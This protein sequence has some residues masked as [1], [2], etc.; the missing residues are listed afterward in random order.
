MQVD[1][2][3]RIFKVGLDGNDGCFDGKHL[4]VFISNLSE[5]VGNLPFIGSD[6]QDDSRIAFGKNVILVLVAFSF[7]DVFMPC[8][9]TGKD[10][11]TMAEIA[12]VGHLCRH[13]AAFSQH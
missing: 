4:S 6:Q 8:V 10:E 5:V 11:T 13:H 9:V 12:V 3:Q 7:I 2:G 1:G